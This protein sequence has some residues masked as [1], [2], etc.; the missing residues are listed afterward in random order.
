MTV[1]L[2]RADEGKSYF[3]WVR[4]FVIGEATEADE[5]QS[6]LSV[7]ARDMKQVLMTIHFDKVGP[8]SIKF[9]DPEA[10]KIGI[11]GFQVE[12]YVGGVRLETGK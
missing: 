4:A 9:D 10:S 7:L 12:M 8:I 2:A 3:D 6:S 5:L 1:A 11:T